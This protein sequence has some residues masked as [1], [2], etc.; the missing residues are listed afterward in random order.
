MNKISVKQYDAAINALKLARKQKIDGTEGNGCSIC[1]GSCHPDQCSHNPMYAITCCKNIANTSQAL[2][3]QLH[4][5]SGFN[6]FMGEQ[7]GPASVVPPELISAS[8]PVELTSDN[9]A[10]RHLIGQFFVSYETNNANYCGCEK[11][12][13]DRCSKSN[14][15]A[16]HLLNRAQIPWTTIQEIHKRI[17]D[18][19]SLGKIT[20]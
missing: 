19:V 17:V 15:L 3:E 14:G 11:M 20:L 9:G 8:V 12:N 10:R 5:L 1:G 16:T 18:G 2:H 13:C 6:T 4:Y 7:I